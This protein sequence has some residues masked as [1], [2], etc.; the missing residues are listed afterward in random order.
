MVSCGFIP[1]NR[2]DRIFTIGP[3]VVYCGLSLNENR[4]FSKDSPAG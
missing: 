4:F 2:N 1:G 3:V